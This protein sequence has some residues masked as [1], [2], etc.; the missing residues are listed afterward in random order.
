MN[1]RGDFDLDR[2][3]RNTCHSDEDNHYDEEYDDDDDDDDD[4]E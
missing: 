1:L 3:D 2:F 4:D